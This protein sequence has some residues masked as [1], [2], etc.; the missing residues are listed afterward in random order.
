[1]VLGHEVEV[2]NGILVH[3]V[4]FAGHVHNHLSDVSEWRTQ[5]PRLH[6]YN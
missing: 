3:G 6:A 5:V 4:V 2:L 1:M